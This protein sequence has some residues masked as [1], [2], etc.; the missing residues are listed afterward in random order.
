M[1]MR[2]IV[3][4]AALLAGAG[5]HARARAQDCMR[6]EAAPLF[7]KPLAS[8]GAHAFTTTSNHEGV[9]RFTFGDG[10]RADVNHGGCEYDVT[11]LRFSA[12]ALFA[13]GYAARQAYAAAAAYLRTLAALRPE[14]SND[15]GAAAATLD[16]RASAAPTPAFGEELA[17]DGDGAPP[18]QGRVKVD[19]AGRQG[20]SGYVQVT[21]FKGPL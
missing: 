14:T 12:P 6:S 11:T 1:R 8:I 15:F 20:K 7:P 19:A 3:L 16:A 18:I 21:L 2:V 17:V 9:E 13:R 10:V 5:A 4:A